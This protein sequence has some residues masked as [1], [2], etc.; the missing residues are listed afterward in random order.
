[1]LAGVPDGAVLPSLEEVLVSE[2]RSDELFAT[3]AT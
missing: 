1:M 2:R 3:V